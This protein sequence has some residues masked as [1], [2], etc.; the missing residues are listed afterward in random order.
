MTEQVPILRWPGSKW[1][2]ADWIIHFFPYHEVYC[3]PFFGSGAVFFRKAPAGT[4]TINDI[5]G[6][7]VNLFRVI[8]EQPAELC[9]EIEMTPYAREEY[10]DCLHETYPKNQLDAA[11]IFL[12]RAWQSY[13]GKTHESGKSWAH[14]RTNTVYRP[15]YWCKMPEHIMNVAERLKM[16]Q[17]ECMNALEL[18]PMYNRRNT[19]LYIDPPYLKNTRTSLHYEC[20]FS[21]VEEH[22]AL[23]KLCK[24]HTGPC[25]ISSYD[26]EL[27]NTE[28]AG[29]EKHSRQVATNNAGTATEI[30]YLNK[31]CTEQGRLF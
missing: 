26:N 6:N 29:W 10:N 22:K 12:V 11:R 30:I 24:Q 19:L 25:V 27:Y 7:I 8:R 14:D 15:K 4:E 31:V 23:L 13:G 3:E 16:A 5:D 17:V 9:K 20:E 2:I 18:I 1:R 21:G 28:L